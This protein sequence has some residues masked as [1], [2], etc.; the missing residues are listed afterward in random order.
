MRE[1]MAETSTPSPMP[2]AALR[3]DSV[4][5]VRG[6][7]WWAAYPGLHDPGR[8]ALT[9]RRKGLGRSIQPVYSGSI[10]TFHLGRSAMKRYFCAAALALV[11]GLA[12]CTP[13]STN[14]QQGPASPPAP[15]GPT[16]VKLGQ[17]FDIPDQAGRSV[18][19]A[20]ID[21][22]EV[23][24]I[25]T[26][27]YGTVEPAAKG[28]YIAVQ[29]TVETTA[30]FLPRQAFTYPSGYDF[31]VTGPDGLTESSVYDDTSGGLCIADRETFDGPF[32]A[33]AKYQRWLSLES[34]NTSGTL[35]FRPHFMASSL[36][37]WE[38]EFA[39]DAKTSPA[40]PAQENAPAPAPPPED[41]CSL[42]PADMDQK[43]KIQCGVVEKAP[44]PSPGAE[45]LPP[46]SLEFKCS[47]PTWRAN[48]GDHGDQQCGS[49]WDGS[50]SGEVPQEYQQYQEETGYP[51]SYEE[52]EQLPG[53][54]KCGTACGQAPTSGETQ[55]QY[56]CEQ[57]YIPEEQCTQAGF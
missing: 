19:R 1:R 28:H 38:V 47:D 18:A 21:K 17:T 5:A 25:C 50:N 2:P 34:E 36:P 32:Q 10:D 6:E 37:G 41:N 52:Y 54:Q 24:P 7:E 48:N 29:M 11:M 51:Y 8:Q 27:D 3:S 26:D 31:Q 9:A 40:T 53:Y 13:A 56:G 35:L 30:A 4:P 39:K 49:D 57:G 33:N 55:L 22:V 15:G 44:A 23:D 20:S 14:T 43:T 46:D 16:Q 42:D 12:A 45:N